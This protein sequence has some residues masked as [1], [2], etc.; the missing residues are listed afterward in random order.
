MKHGSH[1]LWDKRFAERSPLFAPLT[2]V[3]AN[4]A[5]CASWPTR[6]VLN[7]LLIA[8]SIVSGNGRLLRLVSPNLVSPP[9]VSSHRE[10]PPQPLTGPHALG[11]ESRCFESGELASREA[12]WHD[13]LNALAWLTFPAAKAALNW[14]H[15]T[16]SPN[17]LA[18][19]GRG[20]ERDAATLFDESGIIVAA[21]ESCL[22]DLL[23]RFRWKELFW[24]RRDA[25]R[26]SMRFY[27]FGHGLYEQ[28]LQPFVGMT[29]KAMLIDVVADFLDEPLARQLGWLDHEVA[30]IIA[31]P[32]RLRQPRE[33]SPLPVLGIP[34]VSLENTVESFYDNA[35]Y[36]RPG[37]RRPA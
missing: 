4:F 35:A 29:G 20:A 2:P 14:R 23:R 25:V 19:P 27:L 28:A 7:L 33:L 15:C 17:L 30:T 10:T 22:L 5:A 13:F 18:G 21:S 3:A 34:G 8:Q 11:Y 9:L 32:D 36:F 12:N 16:A 37:R 26:A 24:Q 31:H 6:D 1:D